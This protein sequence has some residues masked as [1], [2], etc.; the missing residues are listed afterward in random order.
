MVDSAL[1]KRGL[2]DLQRGLERFETYNDGFILPETLLVIRLDAHRYGDWSELAADEYPCGVRLTRAFQETAVSLMASAFRTVLAYCHGDEIA[3]FI[4]PVENNSPLRRS[5]L[6]SVISSAASIHFMEAAGLAA[7]FQ[8]KVSELPSLSRVVEYLLWQRR[9]CLRNAVTI[10]LRR[11]LLASHHSPEQAE[12]LIHGLPEDQRVLKLA[13]LGAPIVELPATTRRGSL[14]WWENEDSKD[15]G[16]Y[17]LASA[18]NL[19]ENDGEFLD[20]VTRLVRGR[21][22]AVESPVIAPTTSPAVRNSPAV[23]KPEVQGRRP[24]KRANVSVFRI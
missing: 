10:S 6:I 18:V 16:R 14:F 24:S 5:R 13:D 19:T 2:G 23:S 17:R 3:L 11:A 12:A 8:A 9:C 7:T 15:E 22:L 21:S 4:D 20:L 1:L